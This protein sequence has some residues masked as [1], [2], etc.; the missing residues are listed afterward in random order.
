MKYLFKLILIF[1]LL[2]PSFASAKEIKGIHLPDSIEVGS[3]QL[4]LNGVGLRS[5]FIFTV[6]AGGLYLTQ[7]SQDE[8]AIIKSDAPMM[9]RMHFIYDGVSAEKLQT[10]WK[11]GFALTAPNAGKKLIEA[12]AAFSGMFTVEAKKNDIYDISW[13]PGKGTEVRFNDKALGMISGLDF[14]QALFG[15]WLGKQPVDAAL[16]EGMLGR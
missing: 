14:K 9:I 4:M 10:A 3:T 8:A 15:I 6:Y 2:L 13:L 5:K 12:M 16:K 7:P 1:A 11:D